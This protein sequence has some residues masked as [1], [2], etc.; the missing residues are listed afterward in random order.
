MSTPI[1]QTKI[2]CSVFTTI[3]ANSLCNIFFQNLI[4]HFKSFSELG[5]VFRCLPYTFSAFTSCS[6]QSPPSLLSFNSSGCRLSMARANFAPPAYKMLR[7]HRKSE[8]VPASDLPGAGKKSLFCC[9]F[10]GF[11]RF[12]TVCVYMQYRYLLHRS[13]R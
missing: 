11:Q 9:I 3:P 7:T 4:C 5:F 12:Q 1:Y 6:F 10:S 2:P 8:P 13:P